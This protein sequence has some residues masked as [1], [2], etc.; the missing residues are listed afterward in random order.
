MIL[1]DRRTARVQREIR[2]LISRC[3]R[4]VLGIA[5]EEIE[6]WWLADRRSTLAWADLDGH[7]PSGCRYAQ[8]G[9]Q[10]ERDKDPKKTLNEL[11]S[12]SDRFDRTYGDGN[13]DMATEF[14]ENHW[15]VSASLDELRGQCPVGYVSFDRDATQEFRN[16]AH[17]QGRL[18]GS[19]ELSKRNRRKPS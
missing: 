8:A 17:R 4:L 11:T 1:L 15:R 12:I 5:I 2:K 18:F 13:L 3:E 7:L 6:A 14:A 19:D 10:S 9:Y 16:A